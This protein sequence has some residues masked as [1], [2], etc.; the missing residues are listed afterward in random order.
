M[1]SLM[2]N[3]DRGNRAAARIILSDPARYA[4]L[5]LAWAKLWMEQHQKPYADLSDTRRPL[6]LNTGDNNS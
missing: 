3:Y 6:L 4:G 1:A 2:P 5:P